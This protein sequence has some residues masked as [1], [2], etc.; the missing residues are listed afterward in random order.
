M[1]HKIK[2]K[3]EQ[4]R[5]ILYL[6]KG[7]ENGLCLRVDGFNEALQMGA[8]AL[9]ITEKIKDVIRNAKE[10]RDFCT[11]AIAELLG[12]KEVNQ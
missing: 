12:I 5:K 2:L 4:A 7:A 11:L 10:P 9:E 6:S 8:D 3:P 1:L